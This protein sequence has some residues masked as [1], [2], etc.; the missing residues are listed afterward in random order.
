MRK[1]L[2]LV[3]LLGA[4]TVWAVTDCSK[5]RSSVEKML[6]SSQRAAEA[7]QKM[8]LAFR[9]A[10]ARTAN[11]DQLIGEQKIWQASERDLCADVACL[12]KVYE[13]RIGDLEDLRR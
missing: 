7:D 13:Q 3:T 10:F 5:A 11:R 1:I 12:L 8:A 6:C 9:R 2:L 4:P